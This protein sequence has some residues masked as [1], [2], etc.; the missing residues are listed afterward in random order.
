MQSKSI[1][2]IDVEFEVDL[3]RDEED[4]DDVQSLNE[5]IITVHK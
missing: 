4:A 5:S 2:A 1:V 3:L